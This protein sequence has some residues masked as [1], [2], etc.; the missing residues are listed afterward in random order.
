MRAIRWTRAAGA[1]A[2]ASGAAYGQSFSANFEPPQYTGSAA[3]TVISG[4]QG[5]YLPAVA[6]SQ[7]G[8]VFTYAGN[9]LGIVSN[10]TGGLQFEGGLGVAAGSARAQHA[11][12]FSSGG[13]WEAAWD[14]T[15]KWQGTLPAL[16]NIGS[17]SMQPS[18]TARYFQQLMSWGGAGN[19]YQSSPNVPAP[20]PD[21]TLTADM[22]HIHI[23]YFTAAS[24]TVI[25]FAAPDPAWID[26]PVDHW[27]R[28]RVRWNFNTAQV[29]LCAIRDLT[30]GTPEVVT[31]VSSFGWYLQGG[32]GSTNPLP[33]DIRLFAGGVGDISAWDNLVVAPFVGQACY[34]NCDGSTIVPF[35]NVLDFNC[36]LN[37][38]AAGNT[39]ANCDGS[40]IQPILNVLD[41]NCF[42]NKFA[43]GCSAP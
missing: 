10:P 30:A 9:A 24:P 19:N 39:Y 25:A 1:L 27:V 41:F 13:V 36:F 29:L 5:W 35:L 18:A 31:D 43:A 42:L 32:P 6:G 15:G 33:T 20:P 38:F 3:G 17:W 37:K 34:P 40:T 21:R 28:I 26:V 2:M 8:N 22:F 12:D 14:C 16:N 4:Q 7:D 11:V 23:G